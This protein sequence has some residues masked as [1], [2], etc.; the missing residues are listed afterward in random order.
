MPQRRMGQGKGNVR[1]QVGCILEYQ[2]STPSTFIMNIGVARTRHQSAEWEDLRIT[3]EVQRD[4]HE[5]PATGNRYHRFVAPVCHLSLRYTALV[6][7]A[8]DVQD[9]AAIP[10]VPPER[11]PL[12][13]LPYLLPSRYCQSDHLMRLAHREFGGISPGYPQVQAI[14][15]WIAAN[16][17]YLAGSTGSLTSAFDTA[18]QRVGVCRDFAHLGIAFCRAINIP[19][20]FVSGY[21]HN[22]RPPDF[23]AMFE[24]WLGDRWYLFDPTRQVS[25]MGMVRIGTGRDAADVSFAL[26]IGPAVMT[27]MQVYAEP[28]DGDAVEAERP[29]NLAITTA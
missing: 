8:P 11:L 13:T 20:R 25:P 14:C 18:T 23:H 7:H 12:E 29:T 4:F 3:P 22:L 17:D 24:A 9:P 21:A 5:D 19:A 2:V 15:E 28:A 16:V 10:A 6:E 1:Y 26:I 27:Y